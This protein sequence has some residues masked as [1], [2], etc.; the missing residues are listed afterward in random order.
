MTKD[1]N[2]LLAEYSTYFASFGIGKEALLSHY[3][4]WKGQSSEQGVTDYLWY[5]F[6]VLLGETK[7]Q[8]S[9]P[10]DLH[11]NLHEIYMQMLSFRVTVEGQKD[12]ML[13]QL[14]I[15]NKIRQWQ[16]ELTY[17]FQLQAVSINC[18]PHCESINGQVFKP[19]QVL[20]HPHFA[21]K[22][23]TKETGCSCGYIPVAMNGQQ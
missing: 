1:L 3:E 8:V 14:I 16:A 19:E 12:N 6:H 17:P 23:C 5:L 22:E 20:R 13:V 9:N 10:S 11:R 4:E 18:C 21:S 2:W 7:K 15:Q